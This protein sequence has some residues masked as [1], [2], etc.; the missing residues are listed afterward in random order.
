M[1]SISAP[2]NAVEGALLRCRA[3]AHLL[4]VEAVAIFGG[5]PASGFLTDAI[6]NWI[7]GLPEAGLVGT[8]G[9]VN[10]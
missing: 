2:A 4:D 9:A 1:H 8:S 10:F 3:D 7:D 5:R 6:K